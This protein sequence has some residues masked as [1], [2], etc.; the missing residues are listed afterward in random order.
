MFK[1]GIINTLYIVLFLSLLLGVTIFVNK[2]INK[3]NSNIVFAQ[4]GYV[5]MNPKFLINF[6]NGGVRFE[7]S[8]SYRNPFEVKE[9]NIWDRIRYFLNIDREKRGVELR[10]EEVGYDPKMEELTK[11]NFQYVELGRN[12]ELVQ[13]GKDIYDEEDSV[14]SKDTIISK[15]V[16]K[17]VDIEYQ[18]I[19]GKGLKEE[20]VLK[21]LMEYTTECKEEECRVPVNRYVFK[22]T[23]DEGLELKRSIT[24]TKEFPAGTQY[25]TD[26]DGNY[27]AHFLPE[28]AKDAVGNKTSNIYVNISP[29][30][31]ENEYIYELIVDAQWLLSSERVFPVMID[32][33]IV[34]DSFLSFDAAVYERTEVG[35]VDTINLKSGFFSGEYTSPILSL[36]DNAVLDSISWTALGAGTDGIDIPYSRLGLLIEE[37]FDDVNTDI[38]KSNQGSFDTTL[39][40]RILLEPRESTYFGLEFWVYQVN[41]NTGAEEYVLKSPLG[42]LSIKD[43]RYIF[44]GNIIKR[45]VEYEEWEHIALVFDIANK[46]VVVY[47]NGE[48]EL[49]PFEFLNKQLGYID[50][51]GESS[52]KGYI[53]VLRAYDRLLTKYEVASNTQFSRVYFTYRD[54][55]DPQKLSEWRYKASIIPEYEKRDDGIYLN[56]DSIDVSLYNLL[57]FS[58]LSDK[59]EEISITG[60]SSVYKYKPIFRAS[61]TNSL[62]SSENNKIYIKEQDSVSNYIDNL[63][64]GDTIV[65]QEGDNSVEGVVSSLDKVTGLVEVE[66]WSG[67]FPIDGFTTNAAI[68]KW[69]REYISLFGYSGGQIAIKATEEIKDINLLSAYEGEVPSS[70]DEAQY[71]Q[72]KFIFTTVKSYLTPYLSSVN[73]NYSSAGPRMDQILRHGKWFNEEG[74]QSFW[75]VK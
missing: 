6:S 53:D 11:A 69:Q 70:K 45:P 35:V 56:T 68:Y 74:K 36:G 73:I 3:E 34:H 39:A 33:S 41:D 29:T 31:K 60:V 66:G 5:N 14:V 38:S 13:S 47:I 27:F 55:T 75:W 62:L 54:G 10:L 59:E 4:D 24:S 50:I 65:L 17:G 64:I 52:I 9:G 43:G 61:L 19:E 22:I 7:S 25:V 23:L 30:E 51:G 26:K 37:D 71:L 28:F 48:G 15:D 46:N 21:E 44:E 67:D 72:Y 16:Y 63:N 12:F 18:V 40:K 2:S 1:K 49:I 58:Y 8:K 32:P 20:I 57:S 42:N